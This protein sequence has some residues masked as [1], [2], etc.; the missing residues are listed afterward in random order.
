MR[1]FG[2]IQNLFKCRNLFGEQLCCM[3]AGTQTY[4][5]RAARESVATLPLGIPIA[6]NPK[7]PENGIFT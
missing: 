2:I 6:G 4:R 5:T 3:L 1:G 7:N